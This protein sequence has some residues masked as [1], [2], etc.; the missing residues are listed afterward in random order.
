MR[1]HYFYTAIVLLLF[2]YTMPGCS[3]TSKKT[4]SVYTTY[5]FDTAVINKLPLYDSLAAA[6]TAKLPVLLNLLDT[7]EAYQAFRYMPA[8]YETG[9]FNQLPPEADTSIGHYFTALGKQHIF[10]FDLF[11]DSTIKI[12][13]R[14]L[15]SDTAMLDI[16]EN[17]SFYPEGKKMR[18][19]EFPV[20]DTAL[21]AHWQYWV[22]FNEPG[23]FDLDRN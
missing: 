16:E 4:L 1:L 2:L 12:Y 7:N 13:I 6:I 21:N 17:L 23:L 22:R 15:S 5:P 9:V 14:R 10:A 3:T 8:E 20:K 11:K 18:S 19:R